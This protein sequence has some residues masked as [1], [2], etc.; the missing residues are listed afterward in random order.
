MD[1]PGGSDGKESTCIAEDPGLIP[2]QGIFPWRREWLPS[3]VLLPEESHGERSL[4]GYNPWGCKESD[5]TG[6]LTLSR[7]CF[8]IHTVNCPE[9]SVL[10]RNNPPLAFVLIQILSIL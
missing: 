3:P 1:F 7:D 9:F 2:G 8:S 6:Q 4:A 10:S 5:T